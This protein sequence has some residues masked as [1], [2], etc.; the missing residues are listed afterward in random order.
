MRSRP[1]TGWPATTSRCREPGSTFLSPLV[2]FL[3]IAPAR[4]DILCNSAAMTEP[5]MSPLDTR[6]PFTRA[7]AVAAG[8]TPGLLR[9]S[10]FRRLF[11]GVYVDSSVEVDTTVRAYGALLTHPGSAFVSHT[12]AAEIWGLPVPADEAIHVTVASAADRRHHPG[13]RHHIGPSAPE[14]SRHRRVRLSAR[15]AL[16]VELGSVLGLVD[17]VVVG[18]AMVRLKMVTP[19]TLVAAVA[20]TPGGSARLVRAA[21]LV[22]ER[23]DS[24]MESRLRA[25]IVLAGLPEPEVNVS[26]MEGG[27]VRYRLDLC[28]PKLRLII[29]YD[30]RQHREDLD[31]ADHDIDRREWF[32]RHD[33]MLVQVVAR[34]IFQRPD[35]TVERI[36]SAVVLRGGRLPKVLSEEWRA[37]FPISR[38][39]R[40]S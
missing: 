3:W 22:R 25:L 17:L 38:H 12:T 29:E 14:P 32:D 13:L 27:R 34:G 23:V 4:R 20:A 39:N 26:I 10:R 36:C 37:H 28:Y 18:D 7:D 11:R 2:R 19:A 1:A 5:E 6:R 33:W 9:G 8:L 21:A 15:C 24:P 40:A 31:Q 16:F 30:G 35:E